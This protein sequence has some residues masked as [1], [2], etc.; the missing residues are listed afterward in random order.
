L[1]S[2]KQVEAFYWSGILGSFV[3]AAARLNTT[4]SNISKRVQELEWTLGVQVFDRSKRAIRLTSKGE[5][6]LRLSENVLQS[7][8]SL[9][10]AGDSG[11]GI[12]G[13]FR[14]GVTEAVAHTWLPQFLEI[15]ASTFP[16]LRPEPRIA[17]SSELN[18]SL[19]K[20]EIDLAIG[21]A[22]NLDDDL[23]S[24]KLQMVERVLMAS[25][26]MGIGGRKLNLHDLS[27]LPMIGH[28]E[29]SEEQRFLFKYMSMRGVSPNLVISCSSLSAR[30]KLASSGMGVTFLPKGV[31]A[32]EV[33]T[34]RLM[35]IECELKAPD[36]NYVAVYRRD[37]VSSVAATLA[38]KAKEVCDFSR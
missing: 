35:E 19:R 24:V 37:A 18:D 36:L 2:I 10:G 16:G 31:F 7:Y 14:F 13:I 4:Q 5:E 1:L 6:I 17:I 22:A 32:M 34:G 28:L 33:E 3:A 29:K 8:T 30:A 9:T 11:A 15:T 26:S 20:R 21:T 23:E 27:A 38:L 25:P 12:T